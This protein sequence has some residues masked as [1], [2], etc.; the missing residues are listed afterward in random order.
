[1]TVTDDVGTPQSL[2]S[3][4]LTND[5]T[6][7]LAGVT[8]ADSVVT[9]RD[10]G[11]VIGTTTSDENGNWSF[12]PAPAL[13]EGNHSLTATV[14]DGAGNISPASP[15]FVLVVDT[16]PPAAPNITSV[17]DDQ[18]G[19]TSLTN[20]QLTNDAQPTLNG[21]GEIG[22]SI[23]IRDKGVDI[24]TTQ[25]DES[26]NWSFTP[27]APLTQGQHIFTAVATDQAGNMGGVS[28][29]FTLELDSIA[30]QPPSLAR[31]WTIRRPQQAR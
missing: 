5:N 22:A 18:P 28:S 11:A 8:E 26:G 14:T 21:K 1:M 27:D 2:T 19:N 24:G 30:P 6:P 3:G 15:P 31:C 23:T 17:I 13:S 16:L 12:T 9:I 7:T 4:Q 20:G 25:V 10:N 29:S